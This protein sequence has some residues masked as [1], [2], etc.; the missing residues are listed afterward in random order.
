MG[1][2]DRFDLPLS[3]RPM[4][5]TATPRSRQ[6]AGAAR[7]LCHESARRAGRSR[8]ARRSSRAGDRPTSRIS[9]RRSAVPR[10]DRCESDRS[11][12]TLN[13]R[14]TNGKRP[15]DVASSACATRCCHDRNP[16]G[17]RV[18]S[19]WPCRAFCHRPSCPRALRQDDRT[20]QGWTS[21][22]CASGNG[23]PPLILCFS[24]WRTA[25]HAANDPER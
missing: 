12:R 20:T 2:R 23:C 8:V 10:V 14:I 1:R 16:A 7:V 11:A 19:W 24:S 4:T 13:R 15:E 6:V 5:A 25:R 21:T 9:P 3:A 18:A 22:A 17:R